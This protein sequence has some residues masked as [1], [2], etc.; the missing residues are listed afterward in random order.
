MRQFWLAKKENKKVALKPFVSNGKVMFEIVEKPDFDPTKGTVKGAVARCL[1]CGSTVDANTTRK[2]FQEGKASQRMVVVVLHHPKRQG[3][4][5][6]IATEKDLE[7]FHK[8]EK[9]LE[10]KRSKL[11]EEW[12]IDPVPDEIIPYELANSSLRMRHYGHRDWGKIF[13]PRQK[14]ALIIFVEKMQ[15]A[16]KRMTENGYEDEYAKAAVTYLALGVDRLACFSTL[17]CRWKS[18]TEQNIPV[19]SGRNAIPTVFD[20]FEINTI[21]EVS[22]SWI[23]SIETILEPFKNLTNIPSS[24]TIFQA[25]A[26]ELPFDDNS[27]DAV[28]TDPP[29]YDNVSYAELSDFFYVWL[30]RTVG[31]LYPELFST[32]L[33]PKSKEIVANTIRQGSWEEAKAFFEENLKKSFQEIYRV[34]KPNGI[35]TIV[36]THKSTSGWETL[37]N[38]LLDSGCCSQ[39]GKERDRLAK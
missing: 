19:F 31:D 25:S 8:A 2:L 21:G 29:Y 4:I 11:M 13:N 26:T 39:G 3:K 28:F 30:K 37:I 36:Y 5:Y 20:Y 15:E 22:T 9:Y 12:G 1:V 24:A 14:L 32:P 27:F 7:V 16:Y 34:L 23:N 17:L 6:R 35:T 18:G 10:E 33:T 38:S